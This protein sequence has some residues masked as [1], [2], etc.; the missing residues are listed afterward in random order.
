MRFKVNK[1]VAANRGR[2]QKTSENG[3]FRQKEKAKRKSR[4]VIAAKKRNK[5]SRRSESSGMMGMGVAGATTSPIALK[6]LIQAQLAERL[7]DNMGT[8]ALV[9]RTGRLRRSA[10][11]QN[12]MVGPRGGTEVQYTYMKDPYATFEPGGDMGSRNRD[13]RK[14]IGGTIREIAM[15][16]TGNKFIRTRSL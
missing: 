10:Q 5:T 15:E 3:S 8:P 6:E 1:K 14:L 16:L 11:V 9:N 12:V 2:T 4:G 7:L 13:P